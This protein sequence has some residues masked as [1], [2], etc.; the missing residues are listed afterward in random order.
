MGR[1]YTGDIEGKFWFAVQSSGDPLFFGGEEQDP[2]YT[3]YSYG[4]G[5]VKDIEA[6]IKECFKK[7]GKDKARLDQFFTLHDDYNE[8]MLIKAGFKKEQI[9][10]LLEWYSRLELH[11]KI[12]KCVKEKGSCFFEAEL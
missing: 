3:N 9:P 12:L 1:Y 8:G 10:D 5:D 2:Q 7:L 6:D 11:E 4:K